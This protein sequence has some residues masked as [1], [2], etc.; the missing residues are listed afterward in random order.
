MRSRVSLQEAIA[1]AQAERRPE[2]QWNTSIPSQMES[3]VLMAATLQMLLRGD[4]APFTLQ[5]TGAYPWVVG[6]TGVA[7]RL[8]NCL[9]SAA[10]WKERV[11]FWTFNPL[12]E[13]FLVLFKQSGLSDTP[14][15]D[16]DCT[17]LNSIVQILRSES[18][19]PPYTRRSY[20]HKEVVALRRRNTQVFFRKA[21]HNCQLPQFQN[22]FL[23]YRRRTADVNSYRDQL[24]KGREGWLRELQ[25]R[26]GPLI[27]GGAWK[28]EIGLPEKIYQVLLLGEVSAAEKRGFLEQSQ[29]IAFLH[30]LEWIP[31]RSGNVQSDPDYFR[32]GEG[33]Q[34]ETFADQLDRVCCFLVETDGLVAA[35]EAR[36]RAINGLDATK[37]VMG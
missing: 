12:V 22:C 30:D 27:L 5:C 1:Q 14:H 29:E 11:P 19:M 6:K 23:T 31:A 10:F 15:G 36:G 13:R 33:I 9:R 17:T 4:A 16:I 35:K 32:S 18:R 2:S 34:G 24:L 26:Y 21:A 25:K 20:H 37:R 8:V 7:Q 3:L 28:V